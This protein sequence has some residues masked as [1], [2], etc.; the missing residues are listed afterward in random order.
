MEKN[1][2]IMNRLTLLRGEMASEGLDA[3]IIPQI[4]PHGSEY[5]ASHW[6]IRRYFSG[7]TGSAGELIVTSTDAW[8][9]ADS[10]YWLQAARQ[11]EGTGIKVVEAGKPN[12]PS[13]DQL[14]G[15]QLPS[16]AKVGIDGQLISV[17]AFEKLSAK[18]AQEGIELLA[19]GDLPGRVWKNRPGLPDGKIFVHELQYAGEAAQAKISALR[20]EVKRAGADAVFISDLAQIAWLLNIRSTDVKCNPVVVSYLY[21]SESLAILFVDETKLTDELRVYL[22]YCGVS[23][24]PYAV[25]L[26]FL[27]GLPVEERVI[28]DPGSVSVG[29]ANALG[30]RRVSKPLPI[31][32][33]KATRNEVQIAGTRRAMERDGAALVKGF[34][35]IEER[36]EAGVSTTE[37]DVDA[38]LTARRAEQD[39]F[40][41]LSFETI[42]GFG[43]HGAIVHYSAT[44]ETDATI[45]KGNLLLVDSGASYLDGTTD[46]TRTIAIGEPTQEMRRDYTAVLKGNVALA[47]A[48]FPVGT[49]GAQLDALARIPLWSIG[50]HYLHGTGHGVGHFL[51]VHEGPQSIRLQENPQPLVP[52]MVTSDEPGVYRAG[53]YGIRIENL[54]LTVN[55]FLD[56]DYGQFLRFETLTLYPFDLRLIDLTMLDEGEKAWINDY[57]AEVYRRLRPLLTSSEAEWLQAKCTPIDL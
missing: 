7:F 34:K 45:E 11:L 4:D 52:G 35:E 5:V 17:S 10:R 41:D 51:N 44:P 15:A 33:A 13:L 53:K 9:I 23:T 31:N 16:G 8:V 40:F 55:A 22:A 27:S 57:H 6:Q 14:L 38:I 2:E 25:V 26:N 50:G 39:L 1:T 29:V 54:L 18:L 12:A 49:R 24:A 37:L 30:D 32:L 46:I 21:V 20:D 28:A 42:A 56:E 3:L 48:V 47:R 19:I 36:T 43:T